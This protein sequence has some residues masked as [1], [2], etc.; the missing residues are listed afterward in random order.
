MECPLRKF[1]S[2]TGAQEA[3]DGTL[4]LNVGKDLDN[5]LVPPPPSALTKQ[6]LQVLPSVS[7]FYRCRNLR[8]RGVLTFGDTQ[9]NKSLSLD[10][11]QEI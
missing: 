3:A 8:L 5:H 9:V 11:T 1:P 7:P 4:E 2:H 10:V 6:E